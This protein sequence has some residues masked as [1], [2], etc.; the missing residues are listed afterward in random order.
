MSVVACLVTENGY[1]IASDSIT[2]RGYT[3]SR[4]QNVKHSKLFE[5][6][7]MKIGGV[8]LAEE[9]SLLY[10]FATTHRPS[11]AT[12]KGILEFLSEF[13]D[14]KNKKV[15][16]SSIDNSYVIG[17]EGKAFATNDWFVSEIVTYHAVGAGMNFA[18]AALHLGHS[19]EKAVETAIELSI[20]CEGPVQV[21]K[22][23]AEKK[24][25]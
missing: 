5:V 19:A 4:G 13:S 23:S 2:T 9:T 3:Q 11:S 14:W 21:L 12:Q 16:K 20:Y 6:N 18:L 22:H 15:S 25:K 17:Y 1:E 24:K 10:L 7:D 8:G